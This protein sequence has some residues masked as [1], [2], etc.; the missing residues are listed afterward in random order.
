[1]T[2]TMVA[3]HIVFQIEPRSA[4]VAKY[5]WNCSNPTNAPDL[6][7]TLLIRIVA[8]GASRNTHSATQQTSSRP[9]ASRSCQCT[10]GVTTGAG[11]RPSAPAVEAMS[12]SP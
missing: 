2:V 11:C 10:Y 5:S 9:C 3:T 4:G 1:M 7:C 12:V 6:S 8:S